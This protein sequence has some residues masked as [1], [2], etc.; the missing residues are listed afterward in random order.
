MAES[1]D[2]KLVSRDGT[3]AVLTARAVAVEAG[4]TR[5][6]E[7][8]GFELERGKLLGVVGPSGCGKTTLLRAVAGLIDPVEGEIQLDGK[9]ASEHGWPVFR[10]RVI[11]VE[12]RPVLLDASVKTNLE[13]PFR[14]RVSHNDY[15]ASHARSLL[16][17]L[18]VEPDRFYQDAR[19]LSVGQQQRVSLVRALL[20]HPSVLLLDEPTSALDSDAAEGVETLLR[21]EADENGLCSL[22]V[23]HNRDQAQRLCGDVLDL[24]AHLPGRENRA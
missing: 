3:K 14:Y 11:L 10:R 22:I 16:E 6:L 18:A 15:S 8:I 9:P 23:T 17:R 19:S 13:R 1:I 21:E 7:G 12:Q 24:R 5:L 20:L 2:R 4:R